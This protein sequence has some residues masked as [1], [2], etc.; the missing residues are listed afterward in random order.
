MS[1][2]VPTMRSGR[3]CRIALDQLAA[4]LDP[5]PVA[6]LVAHLVF[7]LEAVAAIGQVQAQ[8]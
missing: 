3:P 8:A 7:G 4:A 5:D 2:R 6:V 1:M